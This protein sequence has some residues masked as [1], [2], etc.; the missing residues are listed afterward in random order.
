MKKIVVVDGQ[1]GR[2]GAMLVEAIKRDVPE[3]HVLAIGTNSI[4]SSS[5]LKAGADAAAT[6]ENPVVVACRDADIIVGPVGIV[7]ADALLGEITPKMAEAIGAAR[8]EKL[9]IP[10]NRCGIQVVGVRAQS[11]ADAVAE[12][13]QRIRTDG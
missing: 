6:G 2:L 3:A 13:V 5:M 12:A 4:A 9:L 10:V 7:C 8:A 1:G 11:M